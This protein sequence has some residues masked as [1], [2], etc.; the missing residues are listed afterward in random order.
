L[1]FGH[2]KEIAEAELLKEENVFKT[3][4]KL[5]GIEIKDKG[6]TFVGARMGRPEAAKPRKMIGNPHL[7]FPIGLAGGSTRSINKAI[8]ANDSEEKEILVD[9]AL[10]ECPNCK[11]IIEFQYCNDCNQRTNPVYYCKECDNIEY[12]T[13]CKRCKNETQRHAERPIELKKLAEKASKSLGIK[14][15][16][17]VK[18][19][20]GIIN[21]TKTAEPLEK[22]LLRA[23]YDLH[24]FRDATIRYE[25]LNAPLTHFTPKEIGTSVE[26]I[27]ELGY[28]TDIFGKPIENAEQVI[29]LFPQ[30]VIINDEAGDFFVKAT[31][32]I[33]DL[34]LRYYGTKEYYKKN[35]KQ[36][37]VGELLLGLAPHTSAAIIGRIIGYSKAKV[38]FAHPYFHLCKR[39]NIDG[40]Q[41]SMLLLMD[42]LLNF[43]QTYLPGS[44]GGRMDAPLVFTV[45]LNPTEIDDEAYEMEICDSYPLELYELSQQTVMPELDSIKRVSQVLGK[46]AQYSGLMFT[47]STSIFDAG[48]K[49]SRYIQFQTMEEKIRTQARLQTIIEAVDTKDSIELVLMSHFLPDII[50]NIRA[51]SRQNFRCTKCNT[52]YRRIPLVGKCTKCGGNIILT[53]AQGSVRKYLEIAKDMIKKYNLNDYLKQRISLVEQEINSV[54]KPEKQ[55]QKSLFEFV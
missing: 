21:D 55:Q 46:K 45:A 25:M 17:L 23:Q 29:E 47:H 35:N 33:D 30:D 32:F 18:G 50:G 13:H 4:S 39:R 24:V 3:L 34:L 52:K 11:K 38:G 9:I 53:I 2:G 7:L 8:K 16:E 51:F 14:M 22:G 49:K 6:A 37:L 36:E 1:T 26:K 43:S 54:F 41:D 44:R 5:S 48:P 19:V 12:S 27:K 15:P 20:K 42:A 10:F 28:E 31:K 40:D